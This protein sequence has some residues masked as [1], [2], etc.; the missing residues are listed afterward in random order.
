MSQLPADQRNQA[1]V[2]LCD[3][4][5][6]LFPSEEPAFDASTVVTNRFMADFGRDV[7]FEPEQLRL[8]TTGMNFRSTIVDLARRHGIPIEPTLAES[9]ALPSGP[10]AAEDIGGRRLTAADLEEWVTEEKRVVSAHLGQVLTP[11]PEVRQALEALAER[12]QLA[13]VSSSALTRLEACV[14]A[15]GL[16]A[17]FPPELRFSAEDSLPV[18]ASKPDPAVYRHAGEYLGISAHQAI[19]IEDAVPGVQSARAAGFV[20][21]G[22]LRFVSEGE[23]GE[24]ERLLTEAGATAIVRSWP[25]ISNLL[26]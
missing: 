1:K 15:T 14:N 6:S 20:T 7:R 18:P 11:D 8:A 4:D 16:A 2:L 12:Y 25:E 26:L 19:A 10:A 17:L 5:G 24:R 9:L 22:N 13:I 23:R 21:I 3:A